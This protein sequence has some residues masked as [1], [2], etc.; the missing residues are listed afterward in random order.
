[1]AL[2]G[3][4]TTGTKTFIELLRSVWRGPFWWA[5]PLIVLLLPLTIVFVILHAIPLVSPFV[6][7]VF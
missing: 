6:Y 2:F 3:R 4:V 5:V 1:M 7:T